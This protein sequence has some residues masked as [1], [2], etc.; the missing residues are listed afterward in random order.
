MELQEAVPIQQGRIQHPLPKLH[1]LPQDHPLLVA[2]ASCHS[3]IRVDHQLIGYSIDRKMFQAT[4]WILKNGPAGFNSDY[5]IETP[6]LVS[7]PIRKKERLSSIINEV[8]VLKQFPFESA[9][10]RMTVITQQK[11]SSCFTVF[12]KGAPETI[13]SLCNP[14]TGTIPSL[15]GLYHTCSYW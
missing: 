15:I 11:G 3:L 2:T 6:I 5:G 8:A 4:R 13:A 10:R 14:E 12:I 1:S 7:S 9:A